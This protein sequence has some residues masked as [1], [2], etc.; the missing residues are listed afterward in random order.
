MNIYNYL[1]ARYNISKRQISLNEI[2]PTL[3]KLINFELQNFIADIFANIYDGRK[4]Y[5][6]AADREIDFIITQRNKPVV[7]G[8]VKWT[9]LSSKDVSRFKETA[10]DFY[11]KKII[12]CRE[13]F[14]DPEI[15]IIDSNKLI[16]ISRKAN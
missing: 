8:E 9:K 16:G 10:K 11:C 12:V 13:G 14:N 5:F 15:E 2:K 7:I 3:E 6:V 4:E 1:D